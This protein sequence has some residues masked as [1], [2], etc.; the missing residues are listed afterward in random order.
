[1]PPKKQDAIHQQKLKLPAYNYEI[2]TT[3]N[4][5]TEVLAT[6]P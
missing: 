5:K 3:L 4:K 1:M 6:L 2:Q